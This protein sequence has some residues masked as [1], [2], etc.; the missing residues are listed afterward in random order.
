[1]IIGD[2]NKTYKVT[3][4]A[5]NPPANSHFSYNFWFHLCQASDSKSDIWLNNFHV[6]RISKFSP[7][8]AVDQ[9]QAKF[10]PLVEKYIGP[11]LER[12]MGTTLRQMQESGGAYGYYAPRT[13]KIYICILPHRE[14][15]SRAVI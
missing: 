4:L 15:W 8:A 5:E 13:L 12:F 7:T 6:S 1:L 11:E 9:V 3:G 14:I 10:I 2:E